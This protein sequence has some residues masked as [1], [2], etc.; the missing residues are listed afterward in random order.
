[1]FLNLLLLG[2]AE[3]GGLLVLGGDLD[4][5]AKLFQEVQQRCAKKKKDQMLD[6]IN[7]QTIKLF[8]QTGIT[9]MFMLGHHGRESA[10]Y[11]LRKANRSFK[12]T[13]DGN[14]DGLRQGVTVLAEEGRDLAERV[15]LEVLDGRLLGVGVDDVQL[16]VVG[17]RNRLDGGGAGV[18]LGPSQR[19]A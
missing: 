16:E 7:T 4:T 11:A 2:L 3:E 17:L 14:G 6:F 15:G 8:V 13:V 10:N 18:V 9:V 12:L 1:M 19:C 5:L